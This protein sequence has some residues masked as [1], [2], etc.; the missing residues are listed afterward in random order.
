MPT[1]YGALTDSAGTIWFITID[2]TRAVRLT[3]TMPPH[4]PHAFDFYSALDELSQTWYITA[5]PTQELALDAAQP[6]GM[7]HA[8]GTGLVLVGLDGRVYRL[9]ALSTQ[10]LRVNPFA[11][12]TLRLLMAWNRC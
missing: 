5:L 10:E 2:P 7:G 8:I 4:P 11:L 6:G 3:A 12:A 1:T 9:S